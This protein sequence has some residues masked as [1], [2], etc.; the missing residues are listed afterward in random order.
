MPIWTWLPVLTDCL[1]HAS[2]YWAV[3]VR[4]VPVYY[5][6]GLIFV[7]LATVSTRYDSPVWLLRSGNTLTSTEVQR[8]QDTSCQTIKRVVNKPTVVLSAQWSVTIRQH[9]EHVYCLTSSQVQQI[10][11]FLTEILISM[12]LSVGEKKEKE[13][14]WRVQFLNL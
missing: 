10:R 3:T 4:I 14:Y 7:V 11:P 12:R 13:T 9:V 6:W 2:F 5:N 8:G 1:V